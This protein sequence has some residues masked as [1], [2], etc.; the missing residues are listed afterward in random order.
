MKKGTCQETVPARRNQSLATSADRKAILYVF[1]TDWL[2][3]AHTDIRSFQSRDCTE[4]AASTANASGGSS[5]ECYR[6]GK[7][8]HIARNCPE[9]AGSGT[10]GS[11]GGGGSFGASSK[12]WFVW[13][14]FHSGSPFTHVF[15]LTFSYTC[16]GVGHLSRDCV[17]G[18]KCYNCSQT[19]HLSRDCPSPQK[20]ACYTCGSEGYVPY[21]GFHI[22]GDCLQWILCSHISRDCPGVDAAAA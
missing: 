8:G 5:A 6:C 4:A 3:K 2:L 1:C 13:S 19:G 17:Q 14:W 18:A 22:I 12:T 15:P 10:T 20:R 21:T 9:A 16:G 11:G 7:V